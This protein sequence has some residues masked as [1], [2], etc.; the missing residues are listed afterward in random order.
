[1]VT[2][3]GGVFS[4]ICLLKAGLNFEVFEHMVFPIQMHETL[5]SFEALSSA[6]IVNM[7]VLSSEV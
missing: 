1:M 2:L 4:L 6:F 5:Q 3:H 7:L